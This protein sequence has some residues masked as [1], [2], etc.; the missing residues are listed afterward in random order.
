MTPEEIYPIVKMVLS[1]YAHK[2]YDK[3]L[4]AYT[5]FIN[6]AKQVARVKQLL[7]LEVEKTDKNWGVVSETVGQNSGER[8]DGR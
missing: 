1:D 3:V 5:D 6:P 2:K 8:D 7:P 4:V